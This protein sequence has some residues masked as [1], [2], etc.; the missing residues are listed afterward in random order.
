[1]PILGD[2]LVPLSGSGASGR[3]QAV[4]LVVTVHCLLLEHLLQYLVSVVIFRALVQFLESW[5][6]RLRQAHNQL[7][8]RI[9]LRRNQKHVIL[10]SL[11]VTC[12]YVSL[13]SMLHMLNI[14]VVVSDSLVLDDVC[15]ILWPAACN[16]NDQYD[17]ETG[18]RNG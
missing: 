3:A 2:K 18:L 12:R 6:T 9:V 10:V 14:I 4:V 11:I 7:D 5:V 8:N 1:M 15:R 13:V 17:S 16:E